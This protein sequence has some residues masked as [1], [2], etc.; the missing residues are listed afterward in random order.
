MGERTYRHVV[1]A[2]LCIGAYG[3]E[4]DTARRLHFDTSTNDL[5]SLARVLYAEVVEHHAAY[6]VERQHLVQLI[7]VAHLHL[8]LQVL[9][10]GLAEDTQR[11]KRSSSLAVLGEGTL[12][13]LSLGHAV[14]HVYFYEG[15]V[16]EHL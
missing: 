5:Y 13:T 12:S 8:D 6:S 15:H 14:L 4:G 3:V 9:T 1:Y 7:E 10:L 2:T 11:P 16:P